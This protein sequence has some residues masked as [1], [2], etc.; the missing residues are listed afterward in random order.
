[1]DLDKDSGFNH[2]FLTARG[3]N[4]NILSANDSRIDEEQ[5]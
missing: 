2:C 4:H 5:T 1:M 3:Q